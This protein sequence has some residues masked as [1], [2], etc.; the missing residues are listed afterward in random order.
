MTGRLVHSCS[1]IPEATKWFLTSWALVPAAYSDKRLLGNLAP[2][3]SGDW[4]PNIGMLRPLLSCGTFSSSR[5]AWA[6]RHTKQ[7]TRAGLCSAQHR[8]GHAAALLKQTRE[9]VVRGSCSWKQHAT[10]NAVED[11]L[12]L[13]LC[14]LQVYQAVGGR[15]HVA[16]A[17]RYVFGITYVLSEVQRA[18]YRRG[19]IR[20]GRCRI[21]QRHG[22]TT[23]TTRQIATMV[24]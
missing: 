15:D 20:V 9:V 7:V 14:R 24:A 8:V 18:N 17:A 3:C 13:Q 1:V 10:T 2:S 6:T 23:K 5:S 4:R 22:R 11:H 12:I 19:D 21:R 16:L